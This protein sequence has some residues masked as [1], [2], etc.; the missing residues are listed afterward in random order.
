MSHALVMVN[1][2]T[3]ADLGIET[4]D[5]L[6][7]DEAVRDL[8]A[9]YDENTE[10]PRYRRFMTKKEK[11]DAIRVHLLDEPL[12]YTKGS[13][14]GFSSDDKYPVKAGY[15]PRAV[16]PKR[17]DETPEPHNL[18]VLRTQK[19]TQEEWSKAVAENQAVR[20]AYDL[21]LADAY[22]D[23]EVAEAWAAR[24]DDESE[25]LRVAKEP[26]GKRQ[27]D[28]RGKY[29]NP[30]DPMTSL[31]EWSTYN[32]Q[33][34]WDWYQVGGRWSGHFTSISTGSK[35]NVILAGD[36]DWDAMKAAYMRELGSFYDQRAAEHPDA[37]IDWDTDDTPNTITREAYI[38]KEAA[39]WWPG[40]SSI[41]DED[42][43]WTENG[44]LGWF[45][46]RSESDMDKDA[47]RKYWMEYVAG[48]NASTVLV[49]VDYHI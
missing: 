36:I 26:F 44:T 28:A 32:P 24:Y 18:G 19:P 35:C 23:E 39:E 21:A 7:A 37:P 17:V 10:M 12:D 29:S 46:Y 13:G 1:V 8:L 43:G 41:V 27:T 34:K 6:D 45:G 11:G 2:G 48:L 16:L 25:K 49:M 15:D 4:L 9:P 42:N 30:D 20:D 14:I 33:S 31:F 5:E 3:L 47:W 40:T 22:T 38:E